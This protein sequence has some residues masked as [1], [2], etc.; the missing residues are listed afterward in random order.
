MQAGT[1]NLEDECRSARMHELGGPLQNPELC[2]FG[3][4][5]ATVV[6]L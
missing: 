6:P 4:D 5:L 2:T 1:L 3:V